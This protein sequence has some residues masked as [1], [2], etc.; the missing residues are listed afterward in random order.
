M[1]D[2]S[3]EIKFAQL[4]DA[5]LREMVPSLGKF[6]VGFQLIDKNED[7]TKGLGALAFLINNTWVYVPAFFLSGKLKLPLMY[8]KNYN[9]R[10]PL[11]DSWV[12]FIK[13]NELETFGKLVPMDA[14]RVDSAKADLLG[15]IG[16]EGGEDAIIPAIDVYN[17]LRPQPLV[18][19]DLMSGLVKSGKESFLKFA[20]LLEDADFANAVLTFYSPEDLRKTAELVDSL[21]QEGEEDAVRV[22]D[23]TSSEARE[24]DDASKH[25]LMRDGYY[26]KDTRKEFTQ[27]FDKNAGEGASTWSTPSSAGLYELLMDDGSTSKFMVLFPDHFGDVPYPSRHNHRRISAVAA[28]VPVAS[29]NKY[30]TITASKL[31]GRRIADAHVKASGA[32]TARPDKLTARYIASKQAPILLTDSSGNAFVLES[33][34]ELPALHF[35]KRPGTLHVRQGV[36]MIPQ[37]VLMF[38]MI[39]DYKNTRGSQLALGDLNTFIRE[40]EKTAAL[41]PLKLY[42]SYEGWSM[43]SDTEQTQPLRKK[44]ALVKLVKEYGIAVGEAETMLKASEFRGDRPGLRRYLL[45]TAVLQGDKPAGSLNTQMGSEGARRS[46]PQ[47]SSQILSPQFVTQLAQKAADTGM[48]EVLDTGALSILAG[49]GKPLKAVGEILPPLIKA[50]DGVGNI[51]SMYYWDN[52][53]FA[54]HFGKKELAELEDKLISMFNGVGDLVLFLREKATDSDSLFDGD[55]GNLSEDMGD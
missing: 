32:P 50:M 23:K 19:T 39:T 8:I 43:T 15:L 51:L 49:D 1:F 2:S 29:P 45:K 47:E 40:C 41:R 28:L 35:T 9:I 17:M 11:N 33:D 48:K 18:D 37:D 6:K 55:Q 13:S 31:L 36:L 22:L 30:F 46:S 7:D 34:R 20:E 26:I 44:A 5:R 16:K 54:E 42:G 14:V 21:P 25:K 4:A 27:V 52:E 53:D 12:S 10:V 3:F 24:L 38:D